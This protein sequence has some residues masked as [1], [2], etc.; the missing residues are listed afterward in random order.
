M[1]KAVSIVAA[2]VVTGAVV[3]TGGSWYTGQRVEQEVRGYVARLN[4]E[5]AYAGLLQIASY[6]RGVFSSEVRYTLDLE[7]LAMLPATY[8]LPKELALHDHIQHGPLPLSRVRA[9]QFAPV[10]AT[11]RT[12]VERSAATQPWFDAAQAPEP[13]ESRA[14]M[15]YN[16]QIA[17]QMEI[18]PLSLNREGLT[19]TT[20]AGELIGTVSS[21]LQ[22]V[23]GQ[24]QL[25]DM[26][27]QGLV[28]D[29][30]D[31]ENAPVPVQVRLLSTTLDFDYRRG[32]FGFYIGD[33]NLRTERLALETPDGAG[34][35]M[36]V[37]LNDYVL[38]SQLTEDDKNLAGQIDYGV[39]D[40]QIGDIGLGRL[41]AV[42]KFSNLDGRA[43]EEIAKRYRA[44]APQLFAEIDA[45][46][47]DAESLPPKVQ[48]FVEESLAMLLP[49]KPTFALDPLR[50][51]VDQAESS[52]RLNTVLQPSADTAP[53]LLGPVG[54]LDAT[55]V[56][57][58]P[59]VIEIVKR[60]SRLQAGGTQAASPEIDAAAELGFAFIRQL[61]LASGYVVE[62]GDN[63][64][65]R[66]SY[67]QG[68]VRLNGEQMALE[69]LLG[70]LP[71]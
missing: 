15:G 32:Q 28:D 44:I 63:L 57:A 61:A 38:S 11:T 52:L 64:V 60:M 68:Q 1:N 6:E 59:M 25:P 23:Q 37:T 12:R 16:G 14:V 46:P 3:W 71:I 47:P 33:A 62:E 51:R 13:I 17:Y 43:L 27:L 50:W 45:M 30:T 9:G 48:T 7:S 69:E 40:I 10:L 31:A 54:S 21:D 56:V 70:K 19:F 4:Q 29:P 49:G 65:A 35:S 20:A 39:G 18:A 26:Q 67:A 58:R 66:L 55:L 22:S 8:G 2:V 5:P 41:D 34:Q 53:A 24:G 42:L 36:T